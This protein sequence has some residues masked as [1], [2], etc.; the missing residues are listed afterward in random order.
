M[1]RVL[2]I[3]LTLIF[4]ILA[5]FI[6]S[7]VPASSIPNIAAFEYLTDKFIHGVIYFYLAI[8]I[9]L[10]KFKLSNSKSF[11]LL[12]TFGLVIEIIH[13]FHPFRYFEIG[14]LVA[15]F[16]GICLAYLI[17]KKDNIFAWFIILWP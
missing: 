3:R 12:F 9:F 7:I 11:L 8:L 17:Y 10:S 1:K 5:V 6:L 4:S 16:L 14:D 15:N 13:H 2:L